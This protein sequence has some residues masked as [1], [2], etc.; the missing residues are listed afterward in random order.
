MRKIFDVL[1]IMLAINFLALGAGV[2]WLWR[3]G[4]L[5]RARVISIRQ[6]LFAAPPAVAPATQPSAPDE[7]A[8]ALSP[9]KQLEALLARHAG[10]PA[11]EQVQFVQQAFDS[12]M[13]QLDK[14]QQDVAYREEQV[15]R[16]NQKL[17]DDRKSLEAERQQLLDK[18]K[19]ADRLANDKGFQ[20]TLNLYNS[21]SGRQA[22]QVFMTMEETS[23]AEYL[24]AMT[25]RN[26]A[27]VLKE[28]KAPDEIERMKR[29][30][31]KMRHP[32]A[33]AK[34]ADAAPATEG[35]Q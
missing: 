8:P 28:F 26:A 25:P 19:Q 7:A 24:D 14:R 30:L 5:D 12:T 9:S 16:A 23:A 32:P 10:R 22:K 3:T 11:A 18:E 2:G 34:G 31:E 6:M 4:R 17:A 15:A 1:V 20:D 35:N 21:M 29:I 27:R 33:L 13:A